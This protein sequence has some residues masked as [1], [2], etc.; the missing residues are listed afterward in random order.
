M[1]VTCATYAVA[2]RTPEKNSGFNAGFKPMVSVRCR[3]L[4]FRVYFDPHGSYMCASV[5]FSRVTISKKRLKYHTLTS[6]I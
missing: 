2:Q 6:I 1:A 4:Q 3:K 5:S